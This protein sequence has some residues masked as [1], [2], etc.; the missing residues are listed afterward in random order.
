MKCI[1]DGKVVRRVDDKE[2][3]HY[4]NREGWEY[5]QK[6]KT[7]KGFICQKCGRKYTVKPEKC[8][9]CECKKFLEA[10]I[11]IPVWR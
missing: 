4:V 2:A 1:T 5:C 9:G 10:D 8:F 6:K 7:V 11:Q 3:A